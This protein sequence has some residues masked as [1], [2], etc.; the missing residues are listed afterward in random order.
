MR[1]IYVDESGN[2]G[3]NLKDQHQPY[4][5]LTALMVPPD[6]VCLIENAIRSVAEKYFGP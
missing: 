2:T 5:V 4:L 1:L 6:K 3:L